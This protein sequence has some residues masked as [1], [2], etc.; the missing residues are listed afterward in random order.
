MYCGKCKTRT[1]TII[2]EVN[3][4]HGKVQQHLCVKC[5]ALLRE[6]P[7]PISIFK[8]HRLRKRKYRP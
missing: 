7:V 8:E 5:M 3:G 4:E 1:N 6:E 2:R